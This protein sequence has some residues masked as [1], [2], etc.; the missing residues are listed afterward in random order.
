MRRGAVNTEEIGE[1]DCDDGSH[2]QHGPKYS[3]YALARF[4]QT[5]PS[6][7][8]KIVYAFETLVIEYL[9]S[10]RVGIHVLNSQSDLVDKRPSPGA[11]LAASHQRPFLVHHYPGVGP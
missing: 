2:H 5:V 4:H 1:A 8:G 11:A 10:F 7:V 6:S 3:G 9:L